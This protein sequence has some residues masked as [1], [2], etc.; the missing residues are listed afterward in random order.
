M[1]LQNF[2]LNKKC[3]MYKSYIYR[4]TSSFVSQRTCLFIQEI[5]FTLYKVMNYVWTCRVAR[6][7]QL[8]CILIKQV[9]CQRI[10]TGRLCYVANLHHICLS[11][12][13]IRIL[14]HMFEDTC[15]VSFGILCLMECTDVLNKC[16]QYKL[17]IFQTY[18]R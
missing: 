2:K 4:L 5:P 3:S 15:S 10:I 8:D 14:F 12:Q 6:I 9:A 16:F 18:C 7:G 11:N 13:T 17:E 1:S